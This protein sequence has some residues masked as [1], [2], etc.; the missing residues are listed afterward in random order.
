MTN[1]AIF[2]W[3]FS[4]V[5]LSSKARKRLLLPIRVCMDVG[6]NYF[7][8]YYQV[9]IKTILFLPFCTDSVRHFS[10]ALGSADTE[11]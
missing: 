11:F 6:D 3:R 8:H 5:S 2:S 4:P 7:P 9:D 10:P 1:V